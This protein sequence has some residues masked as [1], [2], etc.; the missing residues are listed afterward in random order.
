MYKRLEYLNF[1]LYKSDQYT[2]CQ[3]SMSNS[4]PHDHAISFITLAHF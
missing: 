3:P 1:S 4:Q 2:A